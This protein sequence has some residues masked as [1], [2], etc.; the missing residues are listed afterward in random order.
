VGNARVWAGTYQ[1][2]AGFPGGALEGTNSTTV[3]WG[4]AIGG[5]AAHEAG[6]A[7]GLVHNTTVLPGEDAFTRHLMPAGS[8]V[9]QEQRAGYRR[10]FSD[11][12][13]Q[14]STGEDCGLRK[15]SRKRWA[16]AAFGFT[17]S[18][19]CMV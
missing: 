8:D 10:H 15:V 1:N 18:Q 6:H 4:N 3:R 7:Y 17:R 13:S 16:V 5:T 2:S 9:S 19:L 14:D 12:E 11:T